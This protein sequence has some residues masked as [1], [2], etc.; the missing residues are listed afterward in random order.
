MALPGS[1]NENP[2]LASAVLP[3]RGDLAKDVNCHLDIKVNSLLAAECG[4]PGVYKVY[5]H[6]AHRVE[7]AAEVPSVEET[8]PGEGKQ[9]SLVFTTPGSCLKS[10][11]SCTLIS[12]SIVWC[13]F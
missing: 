11:S 4:P 10:K 2:H 9:A 5:D 6:D 13:V 8:V 1:E 3:W 7:H 12:L